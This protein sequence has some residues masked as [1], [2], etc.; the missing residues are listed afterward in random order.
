MNYLPQFLRTWRLR[1]LR[2]ITRPL[3]LGTSPEGR[4]VTRLDGPTL[5]CLENVALP[6]REDVILRR[7]EDVTM[8]RLEDGSKPNLGNVAV[9]RLGLTAPGGGLSTVAAHS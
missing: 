4:A 5:P 8:R 6:R 9:S 7:P 3:D 1:N 2:L